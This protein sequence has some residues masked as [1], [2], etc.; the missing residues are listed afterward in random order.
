MRIK[1]G[2]FTVFLESVELDSSFFSDDSLADSVLS[3]VEFVFSSVVSFLLD[4]FEALTSS[5]STNLVSSKYASTLK[6]T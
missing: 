4:F 1:F 3:L 6:F 5:I 2:V